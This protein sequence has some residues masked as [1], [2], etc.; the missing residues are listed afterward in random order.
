MPLRVSGLSRW[1]AS[2]LCLLIAVGP[3]LL[4]LSAPI[5]S[6]SGASTINVGNA[7][8]YVAVNPST[9]VLYVT[10]Q[11]TNALYAIDAATGVIIANISMGSYPRDVVVNPSNGMIYVANQGSDSVSVI[12]STTNKVMATVPVG[13]DPVELAVNPNTGFV[14]VDN[15]LSQSMSVIDGSTNT[16]VATVTVGCNGTCTNSTAGVPTGVDVNQATNRVYVSSNGINSLQTVD[17]ATDA[18]VTSVRVGTY[19]DAVAVDLESNSVYVANL[20]NNTVSVVNANV[21]AVTTTLRVGSLPGDEAFDPSLGVVLVTNG[22]DNSVSIINA[23]TNTV[24]GRV[25]VGQAPMGIAIDSAT[26]EAYVANTRSGTISVIPI[27]E[28]ISSSLNQTTTSS[29]SSAGSSSI[30]NTEVVSTQTSLATGPPQPIS[31]GYHSAKNGNQVVASSS[32]GAGVRIIVGEPS[33]LQL[34]ETIGRA[35]ESFPAYEVFPV[36][37]YAT[38]GTLFALSIGRASYTL[39]QIAMGLV[40]NTIWTGFNP[41]NVTTNSEGFALSNFTL[42]GAVMPFVPNDL[43]NVS[44]PII[45]RSPSGAQVAAGLPIEFSGS[46]V[47]GIDIIHVLNEPGPLTFSGAMQGSA[48]NPTG[49]AYGIVYA[50]P[51]SNALAKPLPVT[52][53]VAGSW[54]NGIVGPLPPGVQVTIAQPNFVLEPSQVFYFFVDENNSITQSTAQPASNFTFAIQENVGGNSYLE[55]LSVSLVSGEIFGS[56]GA[57]PTSSGTP[58][59]G[60]S[61]NGFYSELGLIA[62]AVIVAVTFCTVY[63]R[64]STRGSRR[65]AGTM[66]DR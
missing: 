3:F 14:Y 7:P 55:P 10:V 31:C 66:V 13:R 53:S 35:G 29:N 8:D 43:A 16:V 65:Q 4:T 19:P 23:S 5:F 17:G 57:F 50:P 54:N 58:A 61:E 47:G 24:V 51:T 46:E 60:S 33:W 1:I 38:P 41:L 48:G 22:G 28:A 6:A 64:Q 56:F 12:D 39:Q 63:L 9:G 40:N 49:Y 62:V 25:A 2:L 34:C 37:V 11:P 59:G 52:L 20:L 30:S 44:L 18:V 15:Q 42:A 21:S 36:K 27:L 45:A 26:G 32:S